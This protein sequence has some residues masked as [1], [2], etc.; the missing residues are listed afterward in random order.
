MRSPCSQAARPV[1]F[2]RRGLQMP[3]PR[4]GAG[5]AISLSSPIPSRCAARDS[6]RVT[7][8]DGPELFRPAGSCF[9]EGTPFAFPIPKRREAAARDFFIGLVS[10]RYTSNLP[11]ASFMVRAVMVVITRV[12]YESR[13][14]PSGAVRA[15][16]LLLGTAVSA[17]AAIRSSATEYRAQSAAISRTSME[18]LPCGCTDSQTDSFR[19][20]GE[21][22]GRGAAPCGPGSRLALA[23]LA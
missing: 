9:E 5:P 4:I 14:V 8:R 17:S 13:F 20:P 15:A 18:C 10:F 23:V 19:T 22:C 3:V 1:L 2:R 16:L 11:S 7:A 21:L 12:T 6:S